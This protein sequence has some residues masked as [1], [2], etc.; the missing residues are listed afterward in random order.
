M[1][2]VIIHNFMLC[3]Q[4][5]GSCLARTRLIS[6]MMADHGGMG[7]G[8]G[9]DPPGGPPFDRHGGPHPPDSKPPLYMRK[10]AEARVWARFEAAVAAMAAAAQPDTGDPALMPAA[11]QEMFDAAT[12]VTSVTAAW[13]S[14]E[15]DYYGTR[16]D[17]GKNYTNVKKEGDE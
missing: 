2:M 3:R 10:A 7:G 13:M 1:Y 16:D 5:F 12:A 17:G 9:D 8:F 14:V 6:N 15:R 4:L 11:A